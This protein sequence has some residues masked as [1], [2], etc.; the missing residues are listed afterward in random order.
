MEPIWNLVPLKWSSS[1]KWQVL[2]ATSIG[3]FVGYGYYCWKGRRS[4]NG[5]DKTQFSKGLVILY[6]FPKSVTNGIC[7]S[8][9]ALKM[10]LF[11]RIHKISY[12]KVHQPILSS[13][14][15]VTPYVVFNGSEFENV[16]EAIVVISD[17]YEICMDA[18]LT[19]PEKSISRSFQIMLE[20]H[21]YWLILVRRWVHLEGQF[22][23]VSAL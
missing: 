10:E 18:H 14:Q 7:H 1:N 8:P 16:D 12:H 9:F 2:A 6:T 19:M 15:K 23:W 5:N 17:W 3:M 22:A 11:L 4:K 21:F 20:S 13:F